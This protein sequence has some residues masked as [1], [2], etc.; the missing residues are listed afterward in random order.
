METLLQ[1]LPRC[2]AM[3]QTAHLSTRMRPDGDVGGTLGVE[4]EDRVNVVIGLLPDNYSVYVGL[5]WTKRC[6]KYLQHIER[7]QT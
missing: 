3:A 4:V 2:N 5:L 1:S 7:M 6:V